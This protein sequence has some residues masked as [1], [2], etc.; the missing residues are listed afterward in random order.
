M[1][2]NPNNSLFDR[3][4]DLFISPFPGTDAYANEAFQQLLSRVRGEGA[5]DDRASLTHQAGAQA[6]NQATQMIWKQKATARG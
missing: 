6:W 1:L 3:V 4:P 5:A 2:I